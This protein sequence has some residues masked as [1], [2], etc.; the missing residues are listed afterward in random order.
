MRRIFIVIIAVIIA[1]IIKMTKKYKE[2]ILV[3]GIALMTVMCGAYSYVHADSLLPAIS[4]KSQTFYSPEFLDTMEFPDAFLRVYLKG[5]TVYVKDDFPPP[6]DPETFQG[7]DMY[8]IFH[9]YNVANYLESVDAK[10]IPDETMN[11]SV[12]DET[13]RGQFENMGY[14]NDMLR[15]TVLYTKHE[16]EWSNYFAYVWYYRDFSGSAYVYINP[17]SL[18][19]TDELV[20]LW[21]RQNSEDARTEDLYI[22]GKSFY[23]DNFK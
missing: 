9:G 7:G 17:D 4:H 3:S 21:Q 16:Q 8:S 5:K 18:K 13:L 15:N 12:I 22:M 20:L 23:N 11:E 1:V 10:M 6:Y 14:L 19:N 2:Q